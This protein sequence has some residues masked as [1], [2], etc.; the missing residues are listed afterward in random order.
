MKDQI[1]ECEKKIEE[2]AVSVKKLENQEGL[3]ESFDNEE[4]SFYWSKGDYLDKRTSTFYK[5][6]RRLYKDEIRALNN[7][8]KSIYYRIDKIGSEE[9]K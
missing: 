1:I 9:K 3:L 7:K 2:L 5:S 6:F 8:F 4:Y